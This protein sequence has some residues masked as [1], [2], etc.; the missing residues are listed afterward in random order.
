MKISCGRLLVLMG[1]VL[2]PLLSALAGVEAGKTY[3]I[4]VGTDEQHTLMVADASL[5]DRAAVVVWT[6]TDV[7]A[8]QWEA[9]DAGDGNF[10]FKNV[11]S[12]K[13]LDASNLSLAQRVKPSAWTLEAVD[14]DRGEYLL[15]QGKYLRVISA[16]DGRQPI[17]GSDAQSWLFTEVEAQRSFNAA[18]RQRMLD[19]YDEVYRRLGESEAPEQAAEIIAKL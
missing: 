13:Y 1:A 2:L 15:K 7:P 3:R 10:Y 16:T 8:Q 18:A 14:A 17:V 6:D 4:A 12:G 19:G 11:Y 9:E 5:A